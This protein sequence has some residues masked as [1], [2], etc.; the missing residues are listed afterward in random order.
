[1]EEKDKIKQIAVEKQQERR[2]RIENRKKELAQHKLEIQQ[3]KEVRNKRPKKK[4]KS[5]PNEVNENRQSIKCARC[6]EEL[7][8]DVEDD[9]LI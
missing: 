1:M 5:L 8:S 7:T 6:A 4:G 2:E 9:L 3:R